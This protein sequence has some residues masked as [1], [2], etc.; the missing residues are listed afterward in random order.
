MSVVGAM[1]GNGS[2]EGQ[3]ETET[4]GR[5]DGDRRTD[6]WPENRP[7]DWLVV[8]PGKVCLIISASHYTASA[9]A[10]KVI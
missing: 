1:S 6:I 3:D 7:G 4:K 10:H 5:G 9:C 8:H 2:P